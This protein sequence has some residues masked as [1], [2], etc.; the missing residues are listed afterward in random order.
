[1]RPESRPPS[2]DALGPVEAMAL[3]EEA[4]VKDQS[5][6]SVFSMNLF[7]LSD[8]LRDFLE[9][10]REDLG[11]D[12][13]EI[14]TQKEWA[15]TNFHPYGLELLIVP[16]VLG[17]C[18]AVGVGVGVSPHQPKI[19]AQAAESFDKRFKLLERDIIFLA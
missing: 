15:A 10:V 6:T 3:V 1:M 14:I 18:D 16:R 12:M 17:A 13:S 7:S 8:N 2:F 5:Q 11:L 4:A 19:I 9:G